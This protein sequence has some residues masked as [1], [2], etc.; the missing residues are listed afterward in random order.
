MGRG[1]GE[2]RERGRKK[3]GK[4]RKGE[5]WEGMQKPEAHFMELVLPCIFMCVLGLELRSPG[6]HTKYLYSPSCLAHF[7]THSLP[8]Q[9]RKVNSVDVLINFTA[10]IY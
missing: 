1:R 9:S 10:H 8:G 6:L 4:K 5:R 7:R 2:N 3:G